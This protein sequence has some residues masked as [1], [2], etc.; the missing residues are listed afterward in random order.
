MMMVVITAIYVLTIKESKHGC[1][2]INKE[3][4]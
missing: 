3:N 1:K 2:R 4:A